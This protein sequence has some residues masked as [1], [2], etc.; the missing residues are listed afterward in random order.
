MELIDLGFTVATDIPAVQPAEENLADPQGKQGG[1]M[2]IEEGQL[3]CSPLAMSCQ[4][5]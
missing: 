1:E 5:K 2:E 4:L 3:A